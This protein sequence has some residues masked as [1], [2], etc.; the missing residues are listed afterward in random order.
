MTT[1]GVIFSVI[2]TAERANRGK[3]RKKVEKDLIF[4][5]SLSESSLSIDDVSS[6]RKYEISG[7]L[8]Q[9]QQPRQLQ[10]KPEVKIFTEA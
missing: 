8:L 1:S 2:N 3:K 7:Y 10:H 5:L 9:Y 6:R 4:K